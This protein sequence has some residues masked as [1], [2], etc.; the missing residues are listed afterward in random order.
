MQLRNPVT[1]ETKVFQL[2][3]QL[4]EAEKVACAVVLRKSKPSNT[5]C[6]CTRIFKR[7]MNTFFMQLYIEDHARAA[8]RD[9]TEQTRTTARD[10]DE[11]ASK[12][13]L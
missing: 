4:T 7:P 8:A 6:N 12:C 3:L 5:S 2:K 1:E 9:T 10:A 13:K 11:Q